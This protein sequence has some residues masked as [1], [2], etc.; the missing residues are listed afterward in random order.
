MILQHWGK[1]WDRLM[2]TINC[3][4]GKEA[5]KETEDTSW[6]ILYMLRNYL[7]QFRQSSLWACHC[8]YAYPVLQSTCQSRICTFVSSW[9]LF[10][11]GTFKMNSLP[12]VSSEASAKMCP[13]T[14]TLLY[15]RIC[16]LSLIQQCWS[17]AQMSLRRGVASP[18][19]SSSVLSMVFPETNACLINSVHRVVQE[20]AAILFMS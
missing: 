6:L 20:W 13:A 14:K 19:Q 8:S 11:W 17:G 18:S 7:K 2:K 10:V 12:S 9:S 1:T 5:M 4:A 16:F 3:A 15:K